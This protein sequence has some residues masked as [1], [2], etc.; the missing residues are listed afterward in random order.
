MGAFHRSAEK[1]LR[2]RA[3]RH[4]RHI[5]EPPRRPKVIHRLQS[6]L[7]QSGTQHNPKFSS[8]PDL[9]F[10]KKK[11]PELAGASTTSNCQCPSSRGRCLARCR[12]RGVDEVLQFLAW[13]EERNL[14]RR[15][16]HLLA[17]LR[18]AAY[19]ASPLPCPEA[20]E[21]PDL[22]LVALLQR[23]DDAFKNRLDDGLRLLAWKFRHP[24]HFLD[25]V[26]LRQRRLLCHRPCLV[27][28]IPF[29]PHNSLVRGE[30]EGLRLW[31]SLF[32]SLK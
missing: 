7:A 14:L 1:A 9:V 17:G 32:L 19:A 28:P 20:S 29:G 3:L 16:F 4:S 18:V 2:L 26:G 22:D 31:L 6:S 13:L 5:L 24:Q 11:R 10:L 21:S 23:V 8:H 25:Q 15:H 30:L 12:L 27:N